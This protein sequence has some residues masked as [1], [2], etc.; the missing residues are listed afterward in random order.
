MESIYADA[1]EFFE[2]CRKNP[3]LVDLYF[4][5]QVSR[6]VETQERCARYVR[7]VAAI[8]EQIKFALER[9]TRVCE[10]DLVKRFVVAAIDCKKADSFLEDVGV[11]EL[12]GLKGVIVRV[13]IDTYTFRFKQH[14][15]SQLALPAFEFVRFFDRAIQ[16]GFQDANELCV[17]FEQDKKAFEVFVSCR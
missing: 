8:Q 15:W 1:F 2:R 12:T 14:Y 6:D 4:E 11:C 17:V 16:H 5:G 9:F 7:G 3:A 10:N 13:E